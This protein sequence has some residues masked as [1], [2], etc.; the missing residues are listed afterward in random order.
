MN[1]TEDLSTPERTEASATIAPAANAELSELQRW[2]ARLLRSP[3]SLARDP[4]IAAAVA[5]H[6]GGNERFSPAEQL[7]VYREQFWLRHTTS[8]VEDF[9]GVGGVLGQHT[10]E[11][12]VE[13]YLAAITPN[14]WSLSDLGDRFADFIAADAAWLEHHRL[15]VDMARIEWAYCEL[16][17]AKDQPNLD[18]EKVASMP[19]DAWELATL[20]L[21]GA[22][23]LVA[24]EYP[25]AQLRYDIKTRGQQE[26]VSLPAPTPQYLALYRKERA[27]FYQPLNPAPFHL[28]ER[29]GAE[30]PLGRACAET[31]LQHPEASVE[32]SIGAWFQDWAA[33]SWIV[34]V[35]AAPP[36][37][38]SAPST[39]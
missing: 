16:F 24:V 11:K 19:E 33:R 6:V 32:E 30:V 37:S 5:R 13:S 29:L 36:R 34:D 12:L 35:N 18:P 1:E 28:L 8:L 23:R 4:Q 21:S 31:A 15:C 22:L 10:W 26:H 2:L 7:D 20:E 38:T 25:V 39:I 9:P 27:L 14:S 17:S 3:R